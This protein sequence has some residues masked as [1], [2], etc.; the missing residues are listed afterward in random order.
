M[1][2]ISYNVRSIDDGITA[3]RRGWFGSDVAWK[4]SRK[5]EF[6]G[7]WLVFTGILNM[8]TTHR[9]WQRPN[10]DF[11]QSLALLVDPDRKIL[12]AKA[13]VIPKHL[14][15]ESISCDITD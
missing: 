3:K 5:K 9:A 1:K 13:S 4:L 6:P 10:L 12:G 14:K 15:N 2:N 11:F 8:K 7:P